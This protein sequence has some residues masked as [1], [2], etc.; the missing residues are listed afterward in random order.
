MGLAQRLDQRGPG[1]GVVNGGG[2]KDVLISNQVR[3]PLKIDRLARLPKLGSRIIVCVDDVANAS[4]NTTRATA[5]TELRYLLNDNVEVVTS[6][7]GPATPPPP[8]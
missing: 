2:I 7:P 5:L 1:Q 8:M 6:P 4:D 3:D